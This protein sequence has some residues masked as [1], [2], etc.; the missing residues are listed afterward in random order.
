M[1]SHDGFGGEPRT[2]FVAA[3]EEDGELV[4]AEPERLAALAESGRQLRQHLVAAGMAVAVVDPLEVVDVDQA[5][6]ERIALLARVGELALEPIV[7]MAVVA[8]SRKRVGQ[9]EPHRAELAERRTLV[10]RD[11]E[12]RADERAGENR[13]ALPEDD[14][15]QRCRAHQRERESRDRE[16]RPRNL[17]H[18]LAHAHP[19]D[20]ADQDHVD[21][22]VDE[23]RDPDLSDDV[24]R[25]GAVERRQR[26]A[27][28]GTRRGE[29]GGV[30]ANAQR[31]SMLEQLHD[32][33]GEADDHARLPA[34]EDDRRHGKDEGQRDAAGVDPVERDGVALG[35]R[36]GREQAGDPDERQQ[37][38]RRGRERGRGCDR[39]DDARQVDR[40]DDGRE[41]RGHRSPE[42][43]GMTATSPS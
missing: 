8:E 29:H 15:D 14:E 22:V 40:D 2:V 27:C 7:E 41:P 42:A 23:R 10:E 34:V 18:G 30:V 9:G 19:D 39:H 28:R 21:R 32:R 35:E 1:R 38:A 4:P 36:R 11:R 20:D 24:R 3:G 16:A 37:A 25:T 17:E 5:D 33:R 12:Q 31:R 13:R 6:A 26:R 43:H